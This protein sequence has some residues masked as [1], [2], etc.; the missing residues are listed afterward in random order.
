MSQNSLLE[1][2]KFREYEVQDLDNVLEVLRANTPE[3][4]APEEESDLI[5]YLENEIDHYFVIEHDAKIIGAGGV[6]I[7]DKGA[8]GRI[9]WGMLSPNYHKKGVGSQFLK[10]RIETLKELQVNKIVV[11]T[12]QFVYPFFEKNDFKLAEI[13]KD[14]WA[15]GYDM[16]LMEYIG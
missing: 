3:Y 2:I 11:R 7:V 6:N 13:H 1:K 4:F 15:E 8:T 14:H 9:S 5:H 16:Y 10:F 12:S